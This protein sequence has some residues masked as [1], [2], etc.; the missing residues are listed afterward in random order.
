V[1]HDLR[2][3]LGAI[4]GNLE[5]AQST[6]S[7]QAGGGAVVGETIAEALQSSSRLD[8]LISEI[9]DVARLEEGHLSLLPA[10]VDPGLL[11]ERLRR[12]AEP[13]A[14]Q[15]SVIVE[16]AVAGEA[17]LH[18]DVRLVQR[19]LE[20]LV[21]NAVRFAPRGGK[22][23]LAAATRDGEHVLSV[24]NDGPAIDAA[25]RAVLFEKYRQD[26]N[27]APRPTGWGLGLY[28]CRM[29]VEAHGGRIAVEDVPGW[30]TSFLI[31][32]PA[33]DAI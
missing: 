22:V 32:L 18:I 30:T 8:G 27:G 4:I 15:K 21:S 25:T 3:P 5:F 9:L 28:F 6:L 20:N 14:R 7:T 12:Q 31:R 26:A 23:L 10:R 1:V 16:V 2:S 17:P 13:V 11:L 24:H 33:G 29:A 19:V